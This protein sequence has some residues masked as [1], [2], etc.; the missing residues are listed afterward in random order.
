MLT[1]CRDAE[2]QRLRKEKHSNQDTTDD[3]RKKEG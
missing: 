3:G 1:S 2:A